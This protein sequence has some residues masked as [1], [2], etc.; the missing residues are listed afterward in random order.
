MNPQRLI[1]S[2]EILQTQL[3]SILDLSTA[4]R[5]LGKA[6]SEIKQMHD[7]YSDYYDRSDIQHPILEGG[8]VLRAIVS[9]PRMVRIDGRLGAERRSIRAC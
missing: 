4:N 2:L 9:E 5:V 6:R 3:S 1:G 7:L 8:W